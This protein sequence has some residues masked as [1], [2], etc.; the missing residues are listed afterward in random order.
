M[1]AV[2]KKKQ[3]KEKIPKKNDFNARGFPIQSQPARHT[4]GP[5]CLIPRIN[6]DPHRP[7]RFVK[8]TSSS[9]RN[10]I[11]KEICRRFDKEMI[12]NQ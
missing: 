8:S 6:P 4:P 5:V 10:D 11:K 2:C 7:P 9:N 3:Q 12:G 1:T